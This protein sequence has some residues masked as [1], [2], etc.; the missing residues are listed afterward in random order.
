MKSSYL[1]DVALIKLFIS[2]QACLAAN[3]KLQVRSALETEQLLTRNGQILA[4][5]E[6]E[7]K[8]PEIRVRCQS[9]YTELLDKTL[10]SQGFLPPKSEIKAGFRRYEYHK[11]P[12]GYQLHCEPARMLWR[13]W[14][15]RYRQHRPQFLD[16]ELLLFTHDQWYPIRN[17][18]F[19]NSTLFVTTYRGETAHQGDDLII[20]AK[21]KALKNRRANS[22]AGKGGQRQ[23]QTA[24]PSPQTATN[25]TLSSR[26]PR[27]SVPRPSM[28]S[29][30][31]SAKS[32]SNVTVTAKATCNLP[33][34]WRTVV[35]F[36]GDK[37]YI[38][39]ALGELMIEGTD[40]RCQPQR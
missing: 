6:L 31:Q 19:S 1:D 26:S 5:A 33:Q 12:A 35:R 27:P 40:L 7:A 8:P 2:G 38:K 29:A 21:A 39:T 25:A 28:V 23:K 9:T 34:T 32:G 37:L 11:G 17:I 20:W 15:I 14:W 4:I 13:E 3:E 22:L 16:M 36:E 10:R 30:S 18:V 24:T